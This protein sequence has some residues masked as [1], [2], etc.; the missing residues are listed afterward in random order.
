[1]QCRRVHKKWS[2]FVANFTAAKTTWYKSSTSGNFEV[3]KNTEEEKID[4][5]FVI[6]A[7][8]QKCLRAW[9]LTLKK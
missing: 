7:P 2:D 6:L 4:L 5:E 9:Q 1:M 8:F 3:A